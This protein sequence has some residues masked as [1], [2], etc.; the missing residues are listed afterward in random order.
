MQELKNTLMAFLS[1]ESLSMYKPHP[2]TYHW[3]ANKVG[4]P[5]ENCMLLA[6]H[7]WDVAGATLAGMRA[8][9]MERPGKTLYPLGPK[10]EIM[11]KDMIAISNQLI[12]LE[13]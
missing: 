11:G 1:V 12:D 13:K 6:A 4:V 10:I 7:G 5:I 8:A 2:K 9:F 3:A